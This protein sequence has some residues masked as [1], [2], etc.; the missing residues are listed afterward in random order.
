MAFNLKV[1]NCIYSHRKQFFFLVMLYF[2]WGLVTVLNDI[3]ISRA[4]VNFDLNYTQSLLIQFS[5]FLS[6]LV[7]SLP[8]SFLVKYIG[9]KNGVFLSLLVSCF[10]CFL[11][12]PA[13]ELNSYLLLL[14]A[15]FILASGLAAMQ[16]S[17]NPYIANLGDMECSSPRL[18]I[19]ASF[20]SLGAAL[21]PIFGSLFL[22]SEASSYSGIEQIES[23]Y[24]FL[25]VFLLLVFFSMRYIDFPDM[26]SAI[27][28]KD[29]VEGVSFLQIP[30]LYLG[31]LAIFFY[32]GA[33][34]SIGSLIISYAQEYGDNN[35]NL[36]DSNNL[37]SL[38]WLGAL[39]GRFVGIF[40]LRT[41]S[42]KKLLWLNC[43]ASCFLLS[44]SI[45][46]DSY[47]AIYW[48]VLVGIF[49]SIMFPVIFSLS[50]RN[51]GAYIGRGSGFLCMAIVGG[52]I[53]PLVQGLFADNFSLKFS[54]IV[55]IVC[56]LYIALYSLNVSKMYLKYRS[57]CLLT[58]KN[59]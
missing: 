30:H 13:I 12:Y 58:S 59:A 2:I 43:I 51:L 40:L 27:Y 28:N 24:I 33:E 49:N 31:V 38:Y 42:D 25:G 18:T 3:L 23:L 36:M 20:N 7:V 34:V 1:N 29:S 8:A 54:F 50:I 26:D 11:F 45:T 57:Y 16:V 15:L 22:L 9:F 21:A 48:I 44:F 37:L 55:P 41:L 14:I 17:V 6:Y 4:S 56:Y 53:I 5:F 32:V 35:F 39:L 52:A 19:A 47:R 46:D 10:G